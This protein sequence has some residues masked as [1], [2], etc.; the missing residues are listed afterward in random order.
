MK[1]LKKAWG[2]LDGWKTYLGGIGLMLSGA[3]I[4]IEDAVKTVQ[5]PATALTFAMS[6]PAHSGVITFL[7]GFTAVG[8]GH[9][10]EKTKA[11]ATKAVR[12]ASK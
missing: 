6:L 2:L 11:A 5:D 10:V 12:N 3:G 4:V 8:I 1:T 7:A 9:K